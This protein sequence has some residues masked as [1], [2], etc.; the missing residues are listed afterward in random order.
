MGMKAGYARVSTSR[1]KLDL[2]LDR[3][4]DCDRI[5]CEKASASSANNRPELKN[6][7]Q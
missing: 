3:L 4:V 5:Y 6:A 1:Q 7:H 2:Q